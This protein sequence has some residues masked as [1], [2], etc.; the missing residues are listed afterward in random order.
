MLARGIESC[1]SLITCKN[2][3]PP[4][5]SINVFRLAIFFIFEAGDHVK[6]GFPMAWSAT[7]LAWGVIEF[8]EAYVDSGEYQNVLHSLK[9][10]TDYFIKAHTSKYELYGQVD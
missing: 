5:K 3:F 4:P 1:H 8:K 10:A 7:T 9:W 2:Q 6:F